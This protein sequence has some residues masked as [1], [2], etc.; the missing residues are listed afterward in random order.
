MEKKNRYKIETHGC[1]GKT[2]Y[3]AYKEGI[4]HIPKFLTIKIFEVPQNPDYAWH[5]KPNKMD[6]FGDIWFFDLQKC[7]VS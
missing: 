1:S 3:A 7:E 4:N 6:G 5:R 2:C